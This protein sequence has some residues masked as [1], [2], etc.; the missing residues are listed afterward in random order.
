MRARGISDDDITT[1][2]VD[3]PRA[4]PRGR[5][6]LLMHRPGALGVTLLQTDLHHGARPPHSPTAW[7]GGTW[8]TAPSSRWREWHRRSNQL[9]RGLQQRGSSRGDRV[10][11]LIGNDEPLEW[12]VSYLAIHK[13]GAVAVPLLARLGPARARPDPRTTPGRPSSCAASSATKSG[14]AV[15]TVIC[16]GTRQRRS[17][18]ADLLSP[19]DRIWPRRSAPT[20]WPTSC[21]RPAPRA[22]PRASWCGTAASRRPTACRRPGSAS[23]SSRARRSPPPAAHCSCAG[24]LRGGLSGWFLPRFD[25]GRLDRRR[26]AEPPGRGLPG[27]RRWWS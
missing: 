5:R 19:D 13:A 1:M 8:P 24:P 20:T 16:T 9:A 15:G 22:G 18:W 23:A 4:D 12:L 6:L 7:P 10:G 14:L 21:T 17:R 11:L 25:P 2:L 3:N 26:G 27:A